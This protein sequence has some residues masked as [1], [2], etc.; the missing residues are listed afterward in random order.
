VPPDDLGGRDG[1]EWALVAVRERQAA[2]K[3]HRDYHEG[4]HRL[5]FASDRFR[6]HFGDLF[7]DFRDN[8]CGSVVSALTDRLAVIGWQSPGD[9]AAGDAATALWDANRM[10][11]RQLPTYVTAA[12][13]GDAFELVWPTR[14][15]EVRFWPQ[16]PTACA[17]QYDDDDDPTLIVRSCKVWAQGKRWRANVYLT[18]GPTTAGRID[19]WVTAERP[20]GDGSMPDKPDSWAPFE[21]DEA[22]PEVLNPWGVN[23]MF[24]YAYAAPAGEY[25]RS[26]LADVLPLQDALNKSVADL[27]VA[28]EFVAYPQR[29]LI[30]VEREIDPETGL[31]RSVDGGTDRVWRISTPGGSATQFPAADLRQIL[32]VSETFRLEVARVTGTPPHYL[33]LNKSGLAQAPSGEALQVLDG[34][35][36]K[37]AEQCQEGWGDVRR[38]AMLLALRM[39]AGAGTI[40]PTSM[41]PDELLEPVWDDASSR[42]E[43]AEL[44]AAEIKERVGYSQRQTLRELGKTDDELDAMEEE[45]K[46]ETSA[47][48]EAMLAQFDRGNVAGIGGL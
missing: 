3:L 25:G 45:R 12:V 24:H 8:L 28:M 1:L 14:A 6:Q 31:E 46:L 30:G 38:A 42:S 27:L 19:R 40:A 47:M 9:T 11:Q 34:R 32:E 48:G 22:G 4:R 17:V 44:E 20:E 26:R 33:M 21:G 18:G 41:R 5:A 36:V 10:G 35:L 16:E 39:A 7:A 43:R 2:Y 29:I 37:A 23:P 13:C 15:G